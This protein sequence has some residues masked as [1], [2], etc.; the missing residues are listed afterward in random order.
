[1]KR[2]IDFTLALICLMA[3]SPLMLIC[4]IAIKKE[5]GL[6]VIYSQERIGLHGKPFMIY[7]FRTMRKNAEGNGVHN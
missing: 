3:F 2:A 6:P 1:M 7:K 4:A 5:D